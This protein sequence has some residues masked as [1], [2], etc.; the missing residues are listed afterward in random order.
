[1][2]STNKKVLLI[3]FLLFS[4]LTIVTIINVTLNFRTFSK[5][6]AIDK[7]TSVAEAVRDGLTAHM[8]NGTMD[9]R[10]LFLENMLKHQDVKNL[11]LFRSKKVIE[12]FGEGSNREHIYSQLEDKVT[13]SAKSSYILNETSN[14]AVVTVAIPYI[15]TKYSNPNCLSCHIN[16]KEGDV[17]GVISMDV[18]IED[19]RSDGITMILKILIISIIFL[20]IA[21]VVARQV[22]KPYIKLFD[23]LEEGISR[24]YRGDFSHHIDTNL[25]DEAGEVALRLNELSEI[26]RFKRTIELDNSKDTIYKRLSHIL[27]DSFGIT[28]FI[29]MEIN[30]QEQTREVVYNSINKNQLPKDLFGQNAND[31]RAFRINNNVLST[32]FHKICSTCFKEGCEFLCIPF[33]VSDEYSFVLHIRTNS[34]AELERI[35]ELEPVI[36]NYFELAQ[37]ILESKHLMN[38]LQE[39]S[40]KDGLTGLY[41]RRYL[42]NLVKEIEKDYIVLMIDIDLFKKVNDTYGH[43][44]GDKVIVGLSKFL[45]KQIKGS[46]VAIRYGGEEFIVILYDISIKDAFKKADE[47]RES[48]SN[49]YFETSGESI[50]KTIS[51]GISAFNNTEPPLQVIKQA[52][53]ALYK[54][55]ESGRDKVVLFE[56]G[57]KSE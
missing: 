21:M 15:A 7:A 39:K 52:D 2:S 38:I 34:T 18:D 29:I 27:I 22:I 10:A 24:A 41:N 50:K 33:I 57:M 47:I 4:S 14:T 42:E 8:V 44:V 31:C 51:I 48:F 19:I 55:K 11:H 56:K 26:F 45:Q 5:N 36:K 43:D 3:V 54:A 6:I 46:D 13:N 17:L 1:M 40:L 12:L 35:R 28:N 20:F 30:A 37:H 53:I 32:E 49:I 25:S 9:N 23:D 16:A